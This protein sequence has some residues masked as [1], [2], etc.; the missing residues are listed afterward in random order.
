[1]RCVSRLSALLLL[2][3]IAGCATRAP[4]EIDG[5]HWAFG[6]HGPSAEVLREAVPVVFQTAKDDNTGLIQDF[7]RA[8]GIDR[9]R[10]LGAAFDASFGAARIRAPRGSRWLLQPGRVGLAERNYSSLMKPQLGASLSLVAGNGEYLWHGRE[11]VDID[12]PDLPFFS[13]EQLRDSPVLL[14]EAWRAAAH[15]LMRRLLAKHRA[16]LRDRREGYAD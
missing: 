13:L 6:Y 8:H 16:G 3:L 15:V 7:E 14:D 12:S 11:F 9:E 10:I 2:F 4:L 1:M 5:R